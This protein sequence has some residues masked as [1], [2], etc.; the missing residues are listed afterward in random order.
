MEAKVSVIMPTYNR[1]YIILDAIRSVLSQTYDCFELIIVDDGSKDDT[2]EIVSKIEDS[3]IKYHKLEKNSGVSHARNVGLELANGEFLCFLDSDNNWHESFLER[4]IGTAKST[5][6]NFVFG[7]MQLNRMDGT[8]VVIPEVSADELSNPEKLIKRML[9]DNVIDM[10]SVCLER[11]FFK[12][13]RFNEEMKALVDWDYFFRALCMNDTR[14]VFVDDVLVFNYL[15]GDSIT[16]FEKKERTDMHLIMLRS[17]ET[18]LKKKGLLK[19]KVQAVYDRL[20]LENSLNESMK[21]LASALSPE[22]FAEFVSGIIEE[23]DK[24]I[25]NQKDI[26]SFFKRWIKSGID[27]NKL[28][29][30][31][32]ARQIQKVSIYGYGLYGRQLE[33]IVRK[34]DAELISIIDRN[35]D[36]LAHD[37]CPEY[38]C[39]YEKGLGEELIIVASSRHFDEI[40]NELATVCDSKIISIE[41]LL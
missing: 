16:L 3:R 10:N 9:Y 4:R 15:Q 1:G 31:F 13:L 36:K 11:K 23:K 24:E 29:D 7:R 8:T 37:F 12:D 2:E 34:C 22:D 19:S 28:N 18:L 26:L 5:G 20:M 30:Y 21:K 25:Q 39:E 33:K 38:R 17:N 27:P 35:M 41:E 6:S 40:R 32:K 14:P